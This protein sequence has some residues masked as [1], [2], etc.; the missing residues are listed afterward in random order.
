MPDSGSTDRSSE[1]ISLPVDAAETSPSGRRG[2]TITRENYSVCPT[3]SKTNG[4]TEIAVPQATRLAGASGAQASST[5]RAASGVVRPRQ[6]AQ[7][8]ICPTAL[9]FVRPPAQHVFACQRAGNEPAGFSSRQISASSTWRT[10]KPSIG[11]DDS[12]N[13]TVFP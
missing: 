3:R 7:A 6:A 8:W 9:D 1:R 13:P 12:T 11:L 4:A 5:A 10:T 2:P